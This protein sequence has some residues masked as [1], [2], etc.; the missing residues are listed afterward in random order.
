M[1][2][3][4]R[5]ISATR[6]VSLRL[7]MVR[8]VNQWSF[9]VCCVVTVGRA[10]IVGRIAPSSLLFRMT[11]IPL[12]LSLGWA[13]AEPVLSKASCKNFLEPRPIREPILKMLLIFRGR[14]A[15]W[16]IAACGAA[17]LDRW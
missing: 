11:L 15:G 3:V 7:L 2:V 6:S 9:C 1:E 12:L 13:T 10:A 14:F 4:G 17:K 8:R 5:K 16:Q